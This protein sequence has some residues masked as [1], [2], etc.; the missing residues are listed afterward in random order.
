M[1]RLK[2]NRWLISAVALFMLI[3]VFQP[4]EVEKPIEIQTK[5]PDSDFFME[6]VVIHK[7]DSSGK[8][9]NTLEADRMEHSSLHD[10]SVL[11]QPIITFGKNQSGEWKMSSEKG[12][13][14]NKSTIIQLDNQVRI[15]EYLEDNSIQTKIMTNNLTINLQENIA[16]TDERVTIQSP[17]YKTQGIGL[18]IQIDQE[19]FFLNSNVTTEIY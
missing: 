18:K 9:I 15:E 11:D 17:L 1:K 4:E 3:L 8:Q 5:L 10:I 14:I 16:S 7:F 2:L 19:L 12:Q 6:G 13:L